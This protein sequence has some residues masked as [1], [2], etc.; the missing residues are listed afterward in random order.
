MQEVGVPEKTG[1]V[2]QLTEEEAEVLVPLGQQAHRR[3]HHL[4][5]VV[6]LFVLVDGLEEPSGFLCTQGFLNVSQEGGL[7]LLCRR[8]CTKASPLT[9]IHCVC[10]ITAAR[11]ANWATGLRVC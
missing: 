11:R 3:G 1:N 5:I 10:V 6:R 2:I 7:E 4:L 9:T 8:T